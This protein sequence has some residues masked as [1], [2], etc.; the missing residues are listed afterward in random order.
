MQDEMKKN[1]GFYKK[2]EEIIKYLGFGVFTTVVSFAV[3]YV[4]I[5]V[6]STFFDSLRD[7]KDSARYLFANGIASVLKWCSGMLIAFYTNKKWVFTNADNNVSTAKQ[8]LVFA[9]GRVATLVMATALQ[10]LFE[11]LFAV[12]IRKDLQ[13]FGMTFTA[14]FIGTTVALLICSVIEVVTN[15]FLSKKFVFKQKQTKSDD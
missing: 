11:L 9:E 5:W 8:L 1:Q 14:E 2:H 12:T 3:F 15:Y 7:G 6:S 13:V 10:Y 4:A